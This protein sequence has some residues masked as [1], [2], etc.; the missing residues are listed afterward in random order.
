MTALDIIILIY[1]YAF[2]G[3][4]VYLIDHGLDKRYQLISSGIPIIIFF[5][6]AFFSVQGQFTNINYGFLTLPIVAVLVFNFAA[7]ASWKINGREFRTTWRRGKYFY[8]EK[9][10]WSDYLL[11][12]TVVMIELGWPIFIAII[13]SG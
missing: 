5:C 12:F 10:N 4:L 11:S 3:T 6:Y 2:S 1:S 8:S 7:M 9:K 13:L